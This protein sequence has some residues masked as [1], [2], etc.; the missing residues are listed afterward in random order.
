MI[1]AAPLLSGSTYWYLSRASGFVSLALFTATVVLGLLTAGRVWSPRWPRFVTET[2]HRNVSLIATGLLFVHV[3][4]ILLDEFVPITVLDAVVPFQS[5]YLPLWVGFGTVAFDL[6]LLLII[7]SLL[8]H[9]MPLRLWRYVHWLAYV[10]WPVA[11]AHTIGIGTDRL[12]VL[13]V[14]TASVL[15]VLVAGGYRLAGWRKVATR[16]PL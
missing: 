12:W 11:L 7:T 14:V 6:I 5:T 4:M 15:S 8:R 9:R 16:R 1:T 2:L 13:G 3:L 10:S